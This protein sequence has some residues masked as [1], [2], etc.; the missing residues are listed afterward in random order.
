MKPPPLAKAAGVSAFLPQRR[1]RT[2]EALPSWAAGHMKPYQA[3][4]ARTPAACFLR[5]GCGTP[6]YCG[7]AVALRFIAARLW[8]AGLSD[9][10]A[11]AAPQYPARDMARA[12][13]AWCTRPQ[14]FPALAT[15]VVPSRGVRW[16]SAVRWVIS[17]RVVRSWW[18]WWVSSR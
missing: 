15:S 6:V 5:R 10:A 3:G 16:R 12:K 13:A 8:H 18:R 14:L 11:D 2:L 1:E 17:S 4:A 7:A 9:S